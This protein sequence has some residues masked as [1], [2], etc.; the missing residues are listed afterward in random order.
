[1][2]SLA[3]T[4]W[5]GIAVA[6]GC[7]LLRAVVRVRRG[8]GLVIPGKA[9]VGETVPPGGTVGAALVPQPLL[10]STLANVPSVSQSPPH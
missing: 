2:L 3:E 7:G 4:G 6:T 9:T 8:V 1:M 5:V 10:L